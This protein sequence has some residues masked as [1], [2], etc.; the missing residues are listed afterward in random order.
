MFSLSKR[1]SSPLWAATNSQ[2]GRGVKANLAV[3]AVTFS[4][5]AV[6]LL[7]AKDSVHALMP[8]A[9]LDARTVY[10]QIGKGGAHTDVLNDAYSFFSKWKRFRVV[11][12]SSAA[13]ITLVVA[14][15]MEGM[16]LNQYH[17]QGQV[18]SYDWVVVKDLAG[19]SLWWAQVIPGAGQTKAALGK[20]RKEI[21]WHEKHG[22]DVGQ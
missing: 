15:R 10:I 2:R 5:L 22:N 12:D 4:L 16:E 11:R 6:G 3:L 19:H 13:D 9:L 18:L 7:C 20:L 14:A 17:A 1:H 21:E 8:P